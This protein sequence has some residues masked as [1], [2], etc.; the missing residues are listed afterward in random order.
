MSIVLATF[1]LVVKCYPYSNKIYWIMYTIA[2]DID[3]NLL[4][5]FQI[6]DKLH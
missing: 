4:D 3:P 2:K 6:E 1:G 5:H